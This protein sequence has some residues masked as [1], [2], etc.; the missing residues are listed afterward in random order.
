MVIAYLESIWETIPKNFATVGGIERNDGTKHCIVFAKDNNDVKIILDAQIGQAFQ[1]IETIYQYLESQGVKFMYVLK[2]QKKSA[3]PSEQQP[4]ILNTTGR[5]IYSKSEA[6]DA[7]D[8]LS[9]IFHKLTIDSAAAPVNDNTKD[10][11]IDT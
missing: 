6:K 3:D 4:L 8:D 5:K 10:M 1:G 9:S 2:S 7:M 11:D